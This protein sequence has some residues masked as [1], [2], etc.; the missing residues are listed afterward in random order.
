MRMSLAAHALLSCVFLASCAENQ[1]PATDARSTS[2]GVRSTGTAR[3]ESASA[4]PSTPVTASG[5]E[6]PSIASRAT[7]TER[8]APVAPPGAQWTL[9]CQ[10]IRG[11]VH[12]EEASRLKAQLATH[13]ELHDWY[14][15]HEEDNSIVCYGYYANISDA[16]AKLD[17]KKIEA[18]NGPTGQPL[19]GSVLFQPISSPDP[20]APAEWNLGNTP[21]RMYWSLQIGAYRGGSERKKYAVE[22]V[23]EFRRSGVEAYYFHGPTISS[24]CIGAWPIEAVRRQGERNVARSIDPDTSILVMNDVMPQYMKPVKYDQNGKQVLIMAPRLDVIDPKL[25]AV[26]RKYPEHAV[27]GEVMVITAKDG[28]K[29]PTPSFL[30][31]IPHPEMEGQDPFAGAPDQVGPSDPDAVRVEHGVGSTFDEDPSTIK[32]KLRTLGEH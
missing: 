19:F 25:T 8:A 7:G 20:E 22:A 14:L 5:A 10:T 26:I 11:P 17:K 4:R 24:V 1:P 28:Q 23:R 3:P 6:L 31:Q 30:V 32:Q 9:Y 27:N 12:V 15:V 18:L 2:A 16:K 21:K 29:I 13:P